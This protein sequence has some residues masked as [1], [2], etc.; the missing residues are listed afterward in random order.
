VT[1]SEWRADRRHRAVGG[2]FGIPADR[3]RSLRIA[4]T[5]LFTSPADV[6]RLAEAIETL[7]R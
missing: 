7:P 1:S 2:F 5:A 3:P 4:N 6:D